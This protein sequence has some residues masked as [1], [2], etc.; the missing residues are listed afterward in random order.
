MNKILISSE[1]I[2]VIEMLRLYF[3]VCTYLQ[4]FLAREDE[5]KTI[6]TRTHNCLPNI[7]YRFKIS[8][9]Q[10]YTQSNGSYPL[11]NQQR[12]SDFKTKIPPRARCIQFKVLFLHLRKGGKAKRCYIWYISLIFISMLNLQYHYFSNHSLLILIEKLFEQF[13]KFL[14]KLILSLKEK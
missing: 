5:E 3:E 9:N 7:I 14:S 4:G 1:K 2:K 11:E 12:K 8:V 13:N 10:S 6:E